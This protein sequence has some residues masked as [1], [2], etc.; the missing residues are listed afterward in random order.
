MKVTVVRDPKPPVQ[1]VTII[2]TAREVHDLRAMLRAIDSREW[3]DCSCNNPHFSGTTHHRREFVESLI[4]LRNR[5]E[6][7]LG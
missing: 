3:S 4:S 7:E 2:F 6:E 1:E 5:L